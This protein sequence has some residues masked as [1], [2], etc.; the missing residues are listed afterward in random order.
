MYG[1][2]RA[3]GVRTQQR[4]L[5]RGPVVQGLGCRDSPRRS[6]WLHSRLL[7]S[8]VDEFPEG[9]HCADPRGSQRGLGCVLNS[10]INWFN[11]HV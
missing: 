10:G 8:G 1:V 3:L 11:G 6:V 9:P 2:T 7:G 4:A 5:E